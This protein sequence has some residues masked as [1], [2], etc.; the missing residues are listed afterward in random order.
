MM[1]VI[2]KKFRA[3][4]MAE[5]FEIEAA[6]IDAMA[7]ESEGRDRKTLQRAA[8]LSREIARLMR[9]VPCGETE[10][11]LRR[12]LQG[13]VDGIRERTL[14]EAVGAEQG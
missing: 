7:R 11:E 6:R 12:L 9:S 8:S 1:T 10:G 5:T 3:A 4:V 2:E 14:C 13:S